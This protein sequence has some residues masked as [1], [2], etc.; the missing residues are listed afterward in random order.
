MSRFS[1]YKKMYHNGALMYHGMV[2]GTTMTLP[3][4]HDFCFLGYNEPGPD[5]P[6][7]SMCLYFG[8]SMSSHS[9]R[10]HTSEQTSLPKEAK[11]LVDE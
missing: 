7:T 4:M 9:E 10:K 3:L 6:P 8:L 2:Y 11:V 1:V 5:V